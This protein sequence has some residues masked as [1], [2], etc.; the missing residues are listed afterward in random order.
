MVNNI[1][2]VNSTVSKLGVVGGSRAR[3]LAN[4]VHNHII[5]YASPTEIW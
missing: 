4:D 2:H 1:K 5:I 3:D